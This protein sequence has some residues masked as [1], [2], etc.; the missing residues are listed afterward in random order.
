MS[1]SHN[2]ETLDN[3]VR[4]EILVYIILSELRGHF[5]TGVLLFGGRG[6][7]GPYMSPEPKQQ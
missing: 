5:K 2:N 3:I 4:N 7:H 6:V 1:R